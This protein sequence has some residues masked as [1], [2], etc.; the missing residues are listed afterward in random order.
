[1]AEKGDRLPISGAYAPAAIISPVPRCCGY[2]LHGG[3]LSV[4][5][6]AYPHP[7]A[8]G[9][10]LHNC[11]PSPKAGRGFPA[12]RSNPR[13]PLP[14]KNEETES[15]VNAGG[16]E[17]VAVAIHCVHRKVLVEPSGFRDVSTQ[18]VREGTVVRILVVITGRQSQN[19]KHGGNGGYKSEG[20]EEFF[21]ND[22]K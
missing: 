2:W 19:L 7:A 5:L 8:A 3:G 9:C 22:K 17:R 18:A 13:R 16:A 14:Q 10:G 6:V 4:F 20:T 1:M 21:K 15:V 11:A 12:C